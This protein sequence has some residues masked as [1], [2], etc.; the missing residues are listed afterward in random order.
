VPEICR[1]FGIII[2][3]FYEDHPP[4]HFHVRYGGQ[5][6]II[7]IETLQLLEGRLSPRVLGLVVEWGMMHRSELLQAWNQARRREPIDPIAPLE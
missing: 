4:P 3:V 6:A 1:F 5:Q 7:A 2:A